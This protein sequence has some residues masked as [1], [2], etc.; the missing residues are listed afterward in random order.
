M[1]TARLSLL[2]D[3]M[4]ASFLAA[5]LVSPMAFAGPT[6]VPFKA[7]FT[8][9]ESVVFGGS[10][11]C[12]ATGMIRGSGQASHLGRATLVSQDCIV[13]T[14]PTSPN[15]NFSS[16]TPRVAGGEWRPALRDL[17]RHRH[18]AGG[19]CTSPVRT[20]HSQ[21]RYRPLRQCD[22]CGHYR[23]LGRHQRRSVPASR[24]HGNVVGKN[25]LLNFSWNTTDTTGSLANSASGIR[26][27]SQ[28][29]DIDDLPV[30]A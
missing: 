4:H 18:A 23:R 30:S 19:R 25:F 16:S 22:G 15:F 26:S 20:V 17:Q 10:N 29:R 5:A 8:I 3:M 24:R 27:P 28:R 14:S 12:N 11:G 6:N 13:F 21:R 9:S 1:T 7:A 2:R